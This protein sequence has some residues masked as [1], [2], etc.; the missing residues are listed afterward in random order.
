MFGLARD[1]RRLTAD[2]LCFA[3][4]LGT[5]RDAQTGPSIDPRRIA[6][7]AVW[8]DES[9]LDGFLA[10][11]PVAARWSAAPDL[12]HVRLQCVRAMGAWGGFTPSVADPCDGIGGGPV[13]IL[14]RAT[15]RPLATVSFLRASRA[16]GSA[17]ADA[18]GNLAVVGIGEWPVGRLG[19][20]SLWESIDDA[21]AFAVR[22]QAHH[23]AIVAARRHR[24]F[25]EELFAWFEPYGSTGRWGT[26]DPLAVGT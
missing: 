4:V 19:T 17:A 10:S 22:S 11:H 3:R 14:T 1:R 16:L 20:F 5:G 12:W 23:D 18:P 21:R 7:F 15:I 24:W 26:G 8:R 25:D 2:G 9:A 13:A 6:M